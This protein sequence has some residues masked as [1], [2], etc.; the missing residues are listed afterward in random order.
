MPG[1]EP[2]KGDK[3]KREKKTKKEKK[4]KGPN[5][6]GAAITRPISQGYQHLQKESQKGSHH[7]RRQPPPV[8]PRTA[9]ATRVA[10]MTAAEKTKVPCMFFAYGSCR[11]KQCMFLHDVNNKYKGQPPKALSKPPPKK[12][13]AA[14]AVVVPAMP[15]F[16]DPSPKIPWLWDTA[17]GRHL[18][19]RQLLTPDMK[20]CVGQSN[21]PVAFSTGGGAQAGQDSLS[22]TGSKLLQGDE[23]YVL[24]NCPP[25]TE[26]RKDRDRQG[27]PL[28]M[29]STGGRAISG[30]ARGSEEMQ[31][32]RVP[33]KAL[34]ICASR[35]VEYVPQY[36]EEVKP[37]PFEPPERLQPV[38]AHAVPAEG[39]AEGAPAEA[40]A[41]APVSGGE[42]L[43][44]LPDYRIYRGVTPRAR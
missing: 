1:T 37:K 14:A 2:S 36:D 12:A 16:A 40:P 33:R 18:V 13:S 39:A 20:A 30:V 24:N 11:A 6:P 43:E 9:E 8:T 26:H 25:S 7:Q 21:S 31:H 17:A 22:F 23:V 34:R 32:I 3:V 38:S 44:S 27:F 5:G 42:L 4:D 10:K 19:G 28:R 41:E 35:V 15:S 29:G